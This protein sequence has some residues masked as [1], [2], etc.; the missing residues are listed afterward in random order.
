VQAAGFRLGVDFGTSH[1]VAML[2]WPDGRAKPLLFDGSPLLPSGVSAEP[3]GRFAVGRDALDSARLHPSRFEPNPKRRIDEGLTF[4][5]DRE[6]AVVEMIAAV[7]RRVAEEAN[8]TA[9]GVPAEVTLTYPAAWASPRRQVLTAAAVLAGL[10]RVRLVEEPVAAA[11][12]FARVLG[13]GMAAGSVLVVYDFGGGT[14]DVSLVERM[15][16][17]FRTLAVDGLDQVGGLDLDEAL[18]ARIGQLYGGQNAFAWQQ[19]TE[20]TSARERRHRRQFREDV[21]R[22]KER[23]SRH[24]TADLHIPLLDRDVHLTRDEFEQLATPLIEQTVRLTEAVLR[25]SAGP[26]ERLAGVF[27]VGGSS[28][29]PLVGTLVHRRLGVAPTVIEQ[30]ELVVAEGSIL[31]ERIVAT[32]SIRPVSAMPVSGVPVSSAIP[33]SPGVSSMPVSPGAPGGPNVPVSPGVPWP[34]RP[35]VVGPGG[36]EPTRRSWT[37]WVLAGALA[38]VLLVGAAFGANAVLNRGGPTVPLACRVI[39]PAAGA[40][41]PSPGRPAPAPSYQ[42]PEF[43]TYYDDPSGFQV[44]RPAGW[45]QDEWTA[46]VCFHD[47]GAPG[48]LGVTQWQQSDTDLVAYWTEREAQLKST[49]PGYEKRHI[50]KLPRDFLAAEW[51]FTF[52]DGTET[53]HAGAV[54]LIKGNGRVYAIIYCIR[55][56]DWGGKLAKYTLIS[57]RFEPAR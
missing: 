45:T 29:I 33:V 31:A 50:E 24:P 49:L 35:P 43:W 5:G 42:A 47:V 15:S 54:A 30:P 27:L 20:P 26:R 51:E 4:L 44:L 48:Y 37:K 17:G 23:L 55:D 3:D 6:V 39:E 9:G 53:L 10:G 19:L 36:R 22:V 25:S 1:T 13:H 28:R 34:P 12:Y 38:L 8:R 41:R 7:L 21:R 2:R 11:T 18:I 40:G 14:F 46:G 52:K 57:D 32:A 16:T 56:T